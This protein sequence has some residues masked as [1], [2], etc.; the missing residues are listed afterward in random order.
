M[1]QYSKRSQE[2]RSEDGRGQ[3]DVSD[4]PWWLLHLEIRHILFSW[5]KLSFFLSFFKKY[6]SKNANETSFKKLTVM[7]NVN[8]S[9]ITKEKEIIS[10]ILILLGRREKKVCKKKVRQLAIEAL[11]F[12]NPL[13]CSPKWTMFKLLPLESQSKV[14]DAFSNWKLWGLLKLKFPLRKVTP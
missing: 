3:N 8:I 2:S 13:F 6:S 10:L 9:M 11:G 5:W 7:K 12:P 14:Q 4:I 1:P